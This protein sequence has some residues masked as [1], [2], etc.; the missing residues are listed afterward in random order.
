M[1]ATPALSTFAAPSA[2]SSYSTPS[3]YSSYAATPTGRVSPT[4]TTYS[5][6]RMG[7]LPAAPVIHSRPIVSGAQNL[8]A[9]LTTLPLGT[10]NLSATLT[11]L[12][13]GRF[14]VYGSTRSTL[15]PSSRYMVRVSQAASTGGAPLKQVHQICGRTDVPEGDADGKED[16]HAHGQVEGTPVMDLGPP[17]APMMGCGG[18]DKWTATLTGKEPGVT[19]VQVIKR[20]RGAFEDAAVFKVHIG[21]V[22]ADI[23]FDKNNAVAPDGT[24]CPLIGK[25]E[26]P[27]PVLADGPDGSSND[28]KPEIVD[29]IQLAVGEEHTFERNVN[30]SIG[31]DWELY[32]VFPHIACVTIS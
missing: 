1:S 19:L 12:P 25:P 3:I 5:A 22:D 28:A 24:A 26:G 29:T 21:D 4:Y 7:T 16:E 6:G 17:P 20:Y 9:T 11:K 27:Q 13:M 15:L 18:W 31:E 14:S 32:H 8:S 30:S 10:Q 23:G 2:Y